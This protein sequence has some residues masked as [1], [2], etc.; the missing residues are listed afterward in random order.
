MNTS[1]IEPI[2]RDAAEPG[3]QEPLSAPPLKAGLPWRTLTCL[4]FGLALLIIMAEV[5][6][7]SGSILDT[8]GQAWSFNE[9]VGFGSLSSRAGWRADFTGAIRV[10][11]SFWPSTSQWT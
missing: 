4:T 9:L 8:V 5:S 7:L 3:P 10:R 11:G 2:T 6:R 1:T